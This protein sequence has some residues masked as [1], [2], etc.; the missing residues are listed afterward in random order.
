MS[1]TGIAAPAPALALLQSHELLGILNLLNGNGEEARLVGGAVR[2]ALLGKPVSEFDIATTATPETVAARA[3][4]ANLRAVPTGLAHGTVT[5]IIDGH[6]FEVTSLREDIETDGRHAVV[7][8]SR[9]FAADA[10]RRDFTMNALSLSR[11][12]VLYDYVGGL[13][14]I[15]TKRLRFIGDP[16]ARIKEDY[17]RVLRFFRFSAG[18]AEGPLDTA[19]LL[20]CIRARDGLAR[21]SRERVRNE[22]LKL[23][24]AP[25]A[26]E[27][28]REM[29]QAG[30]LGPLLASAPN[31]RRLENLLN[32]R[33]G[34]ELDPILN[35]AALC[36][37]LPED[38][39]RLREKLRLS[40][41]EHQRLVKAADALETLHDL[42]T[43]PD[44][45]GL[46]TLLF[47]YGRRGACDALLLAA[48]QARD[49]ADFWRK[50]L[51]FL[52]EAKEPRLP[53]G[54]NDLLARGITDGKAVGETLRLLEARWIEAGFPQD[55]PSLA[56]LLNQAIVETHDR[57]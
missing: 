33:P 3:Q 43:P 13:D 7:R 27:V 5:V 51:S 23:L 25:R 36:L 17:L 9:D 31:P 19:G 53:F 49:D 10:Q 34:E 20:A 4:A 11:D 35:L 28:T 30:L 29:S 38:A 18:Y 55:A 24:A 15:T 41:P 8:F 47:R 21:L 32:L 45:R 2:N 39:H 37:N 44:E 56:A 14:D 50:A 40:N 54:G 46:L 12:G 22:V 1:V 16:A 48:S 52:R 42:D 26:G 6:P 57:S